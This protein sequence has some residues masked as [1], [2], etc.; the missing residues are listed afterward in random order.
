[1]A[2]LRSGRL[3]A[4]LLL[5]VL[6]SEVRA[7]VPHTSDIELVV[8]GRVDDEC[9]A[10]GNNSECALNALQRRSHFKGRQGPESGER[11]ASGAPLCPDFDWR[12][13]AN[14]DFEGLPEGELDD[15][16]AGDDSSEGE[17]GKGEGE[18]KAQGIND[19][20]P[21]PEGAGLQPWDK[22]TVTMCHGP[23]GRPC[24][25]GKTC[26]VKW[27]GTFSQCMDCS[28]KHFAKSC[29]KMD[30]YMRY[31]AIHTCK[32]TCLDTKCYNDYWCLKPHVCVTD[33]ESN[34]G[35]CASCKSKKFWHNSCWS[36]DA[37][38]KRRAQTRCHRHCVHR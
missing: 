3:V 17:E 4:K 28:A 1:M 23:N 11:F 24:P 34:W 27:D 31:A 29:Q 22:T 18:L 9:H 32:R 2:G 5:L 21:G 30:D 8:S 12:V 35:Q 7:E 15:D 16:W 14:D 6:A 25:H 19:A 13:D 36:L 37:N 38:L 10:T 26:I 20:D 33:A